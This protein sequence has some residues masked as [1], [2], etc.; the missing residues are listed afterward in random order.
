M[1]HLRVARGRFRLLCS[2]VHGDDEMAGD[3]CRVPGLFV[4]RVFVMT[5][6][7]TDRYLFVF[8]QAIQDMYRAR[9]SR[10]IRPGSS[11]EARSW[12]A[13]RIGMMFK[14]SMDMSEDIY[15]AMLS[16][17]FQGE[18]RGLTAISHDSARSSLVDSV[19]YRLVSC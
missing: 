15:Q 10:T 9:K 5:L 2:T 8:L 7:M 16:R 4:P 1:R 6:S 13:T 11:S 18:F 12:T 17:G 19:L 14:K 3:F